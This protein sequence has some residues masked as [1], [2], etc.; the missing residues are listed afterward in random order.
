M[1]GGE[2]PLKRKL[3][4]D[5]ATLHSQPE[6]KSK[7]QEGCRANRLV[8]ILKTNGQRHAAMRNQESFVKNVPENV[9]EV[10]K[11]VPRGSPLRSKVQQH[12]S[13]GHMV[14]ILK[15]NVQD[16]GTMGHNRDAHEERSSSMLSQAWSGGAQKA[17]KT[18][19]L[20]HMSSCYVDLSA[21]K[22]NAKQV[23]KVRPP[24]STKEDDV[25]EMML[26]CHRDYW[27]EKADS[28][29][30]RNVETASSK[31]VYVTTDECFNMHADIY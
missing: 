21:S 26:R 4:A 16:S 11:A 1:T 20:E 30:A 15:R 7:A 10:G 31:Q 27:A 28:E 23:K 5:D 25:V 19:S 8:S 2:L 9:Q 18:L 29:A 13:K 12:G 22:V 24:E 14:S 3:A 17:A 6:L